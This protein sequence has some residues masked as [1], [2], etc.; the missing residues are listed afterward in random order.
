M[1]ISKESHSLLKLMEGFL[2]GMA[3]GNIKFHIE[4]G[5]SP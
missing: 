1:D 2:G 5:N 3:G 4:K